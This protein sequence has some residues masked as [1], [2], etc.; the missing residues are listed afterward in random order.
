MARPSKPVDLVEGHRTKDELS[1]RRDAEKAMLTGTPMQNFFLF[2]D[3]PKAAKEFKRLKE[4]L[5]KIG[6]DDDLYSRVVNDH[7]LLVEECEQMLEIRDQFIVSKSELQQAYRNGECGD[8][9]DRGIGASEYYR[10]L[11]KL[12]DNIISCDRSLME[13]RKMILNIDRENIL[14]AQSALRSI[15]KKPQGKKAATGMEAFMKKRAEA[16]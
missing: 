4:L 7:C 9:K 2:K 5:G 10:L 16:I 8:P 13:K 6:K 14:T 11:A 1:I 12:S 15:P 3:H